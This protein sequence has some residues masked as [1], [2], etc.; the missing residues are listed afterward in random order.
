MKLKML[1]WYMARRM[2][3]LSRTH[4]GFI[5][6]VH[7]RDFVI[8]I[9]SASGRTVRYF[10]V[11]HNR[12]QSKPEAHPSPDLTITFRHGDYGF[13]VLTATDKSVFMQGIQEQKIKVEG[14]FALLMWF[15]SISRFLRPK[16]TGLAKRARKV[17]S[18]AA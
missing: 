13:T 4:P 2:E 17:S 6:K 16:R 15:T 11:Q 5:A 8:Q 10:Q 12:V 1:L 7:G 14:D 18:P 3:L 9:Q